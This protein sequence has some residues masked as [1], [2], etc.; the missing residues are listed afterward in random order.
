[1]VVGMWALP[2]QQ[3]SL[4]P[5][6][7]RAG[8]SHVLTVPDIGFFRIVCD[9]VNHLFYQLRPAN[10]SINDSIVMRLDVK[11]ET[12]TL[13]EQPTGYAG[14]AALIRFALTPAGTLWYLDQMKNGVYTAVEFDSDGEAKSET[15]LDT[16]PGL[17]M[18]RFAVS[19]DDSILVGGFF[20]KDAAPERRGQS[21]LAFFRS[22]GVLAANA[23]QFLTRVN[24]AD[25][26]QT[27]RVESAVTLGSDGNFYVL[28]RN[29]ILVISE[30]GEL[31]R[32]INFQP[33]EGKG[34]VY[35][36]DLSGGLLSIEFL[37]STPGTSF[38]RPEFL[39]LETATGAPFAVYKTSED[40]GDVC[41]CFSRRDGYL[42]SKIANGKIE[43]VTAPLQ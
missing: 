12:P 32:R 33:P 34:E 39:V 14:K 2:Q 31:I 19:D 22:G 15:H 30:G 40:L 10:F 7:L 36:L 43:L 20:T 38:L 18:T 5:T 41:L 8:E 9:G 29:S 27:H 16:P 35:K 24:L 26:D 28:N 3:S 21:Y 25:F 13:Y 17:L 6:V 1:M 4:Q 37:I 42:F 11:T 23:S